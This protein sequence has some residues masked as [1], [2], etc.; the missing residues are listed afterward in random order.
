MITVAEYPNEGYILML[1]KDTAKRCCVLC[2][3]NFLKEKRFQVNENE[4]YLTIYSF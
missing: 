4:N 3:K 1:K 2:I